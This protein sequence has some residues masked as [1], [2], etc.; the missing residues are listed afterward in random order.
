MT[1]GRVFTSKQIRAR[2]LLQEATRELLSTARSF[3]RMGAKAPEMRAAA[4]LF[5]HAEEQL[6][7]ANTDADRKA[8]QEVHK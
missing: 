3:A 4:R 6:N 8:F 5:A 7:H 2:T 1:T